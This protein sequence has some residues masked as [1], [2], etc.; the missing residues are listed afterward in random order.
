MRFAAPEW[1]LLLPALVVAAWWW[2]R[3][4][5]RRPL[6]AACLGLLV[7][8]VARP[9]L[10]R[11]GDG[12]DLWVLLDRSAS[13][14]GL[15][16]K[17][18]PEYD[19]LLRSGQGSSDRLHFIDFAGTPVRRGEGEIT[20]HEVG[21]TRTALALE[22]TLGQ[23]APDRLARL[24]VISD[25]FATEPLVSVADALERSG[26]PMDFRLL[27][28]GTGADFRVASLD[29]P[30]R[31]Q[32]G[33]ACLLEAMILGTADAD[34]PYEV[35][36]DGVVIGSGTVTVAGGQARLRF[37]DRVRTAGAHRYAIT[38]APASDAHPEN[39]TAEAWV[40]VIGGARV[41]LVSAY[42]Q[43]PLAVVLQQGG[44]RVEVVTDPTRLTVGAISSTRAVIINNVPAHRLPA[45]FVNA[46][47][48]FVRE[49]GG[50]L[51]MCG[52]KFSFGSGGYFSSAIDPLLP[53]SLELRREHRKL[54]VAMAIILDRSGS[55]AVSVS[56]GSGTVT[57]MELADEGAARAVELLGEQDL[58]TIFAVDSK[59]H[60]VVPLMEVG[61]SRAEILRR[62]RSIRSEGGGIFVYEGLKAG[63]EELKKSDVGQR[64]VI[65]FADAADAE[66]PGDYINLLKE[67]TD[68][69]ATVSVIGMGTPQD[70]DA[71]LLE[72]VARL[73]KGRVLFN[74]NAAELPGLF[75][76]ETV[77][78][79]RS[80]F[81]TDPTP[82]QSTSGWLEIA[83]AALPWPAEI[84][85][86]NLAYLRPGAT[87]AALSGD[88]Y[89]AP[90][91]SWW[92]R[93]LGRTAAVCFPLAGEKSG[94]ARAWPRYAEFAGTLGRWLAGQEAP[95][96]LGIA[97][98]IRGT[99]LTLDLFYDRD[100]STR[101][102]SESPRLLLSGSEAATSRV[103]QWSRLAP[104]QFRAR[105][106]LRPGEPVRGVVQLG[107]STLPFGPLMVGGDVEWQFRPE[108]PRELRALS[109]RTGG[110]ERLDL[111]T[112][113]E[114]P[115]Q[116]RFRDL[117][118]WLLAALVCGV[119]VE[120]L[121]TRVRG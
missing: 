107:A 79:A 45:D 20:I 94:M 9:Q 83:G 74:E 40:E 84:D 46:L 47:D 11:A 29:A 101:V 34:C 117:Q 21:E 50:G 98:Q 52:G 99:E 42:E 85:G 19:A 111:A 89:A 2:P 80:A 3:L 115:K 30:Q 92:Q 28:T 63:W 57:K 14:A 18:L 69:G 39:N 61:P 23:L 37:T 112:A 88:E 4:G 109:A 82:L 41:L 12:M 75:A 100:L 78:V 64:H 97:T 27:L 5:L 24:L 71:R 104:G 32:A 105:T 72:D 110:R 55:M 60:S 8:L 35:K 10:R 103:V 70:V 56:G 87:A 68:G 36:R 65:L 53:V 102:A 6:R 76:Q 31:V 44:F 54:R 33:E 38:I 66:E 58:V 113:W 22:Y 51:L 118:G 43:D 62:T 95:P 106:A 1:F 16:A 7:L 121:V 120:A 25:G 93:G 59:A 96:G 77:A 17:A 91:V 15:L 49:Q 67:I 114:A 119:V 108:A 90:L 86:Y 81:L 13:A 48:F 116:E 73:G 26:V